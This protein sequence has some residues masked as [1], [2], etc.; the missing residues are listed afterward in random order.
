M[1]RSQKCAKRHNWPKSKFTAGIEASVVRG[2]CYGT[3]NPYP[4]GWQKM[5]IFATGSYQPNSMKEH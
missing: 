2:F 3:L 5:T 4:D 1:N